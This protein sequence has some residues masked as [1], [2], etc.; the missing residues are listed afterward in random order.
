MGGGRWLDAGVWVEGVE[1]GAGRKVEFTRWKEREGLVG[2]GLCR[3]WREGRQ[4]TRNR[5]GG[6]VEGV[7]GMV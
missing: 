7:D 5:G 1:R 6:W 3:M 4:W 2:G